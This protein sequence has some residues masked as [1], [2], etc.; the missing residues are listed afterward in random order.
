MPNERVYVTWKQLKELGWPFSRVHTYRLMQR[1]VNPV[2]ACI[3]LGGYHG[4]RVIW[5]LAEM[6][7]WIEEQGETSPRL[8]FPN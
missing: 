3:K 5:R 8:L 7:A 6:I 2:P 4:S 1:E